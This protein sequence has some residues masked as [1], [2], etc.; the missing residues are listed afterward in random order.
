LQDSETLKRRAAEAILG[1]IPKTVSQVYFAS[2][3]EHDQLEAVMGWLDVL[4]DGYLNRHLI[5]G[6]LELLVVRIMPEVTEKGAGEMLDERLG[7]NGPS[8]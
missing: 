7:L 3:D 8:S 6:I 4:S 2:G 1:G 5:F